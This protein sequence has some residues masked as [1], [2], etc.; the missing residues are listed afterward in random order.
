MDQFVH[1]DVWD[2][3]ELLIIGKGAE[4]ERSWFTTVWQRLQ[5]NGKYPCYPG[6][7]NCLHLTYMHF[8]NAELDNGTPLCQNY[9]ETV[10]AILTGGQYIRAF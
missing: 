2:I 7:V 3:N 9:L 8:R 10:L 6:G 5:E 1:I 4:V